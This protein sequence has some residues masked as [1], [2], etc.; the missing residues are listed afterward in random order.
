MVHE[1]AADLERL[2][3]LLDASY[4]RAG[5]HLRSIFTAE[6]RVS[7]AD[8]PPILV[9]VQVMDLAT[10]TASCEPRVAPVDGLFYRG[11]LWFGSA[12]NSARFRNI[13]KRPSVS[14]TISRGEE[15]AV[16]VHGEAHEGDVSAPPLEPFRGYLREVYGQDWD[17]FGP[18]AAY[19]RIHA[20]TMFTFAN[21]R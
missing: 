20:Q 9:G 2:Q 19:A 13:R 10:V 14:A 3:A 15:F 5:A 21:H 7:A 8:L 18:A 12:H 6:R 17:E 4:E 11:E 1:T 16:V